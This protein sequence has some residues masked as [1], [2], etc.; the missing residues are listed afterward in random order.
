VRITDLVD[1]DMSRSLRGFLIL[2]LGFWCLA[3]APL[4]AETTLPE[5][6]H[7]CDDAGEWAPFTYRERVNGRV[8]GRLTGF[9]VDVIARI[10]HRAGQRYRITLL[11]WKR[12]LA[13]VAEGGRFRMVL[14]ASF[15]RERARHYLFSDPVYVTVPNY[16]YSREAFPQGLNIRT[17]ADF[18]RY[19]V[20]GLLGYNYRIYG[21]SEQQID[22]STRN[23]GALIAKLHS[24]RCQVFIE[25]YEI[26][27]GYGLT[28]HHDYLLLP[29]FAHAPLPYMKPTKFY[30]LFSR[31]AE[32]RRLQAIVNRGLEVL[33][34]SGA[35][36]KMRAHYLAH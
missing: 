2:S 1:T 10:F 3:S 4:R 12:C 24:N 11:P 29:W 21:L 16:F 5:V 20:C 14:N 18:K 6:V 27:A 13:E 33:K 32:G 35:L 8:S 19:R 34:A 30:M 36:R 9:T 28:H 23:F 31:D 17:P 15:N 25:Q 7:I 22:T 26:I